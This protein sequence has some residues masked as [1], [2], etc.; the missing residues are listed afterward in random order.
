MSSGTGLPIG[1]EMSDTKTASKPYV[2]KNRTETLKKFEA[3]S[4]S[5]SHCRAI[6]DC[7]YKIETA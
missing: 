1:V 3:R 7:V 4:Y 2:A 5:E 6:D